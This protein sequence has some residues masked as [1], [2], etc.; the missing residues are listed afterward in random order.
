MKQYFKTTKVHHCFNQELNE[1]QPKKCKC[2]KFISREFA[3]GL[4]SDGVADWIIIYPQGVSSFDIILKGI[5][6]KTPRAQTI[7]KAHIQRYIDQIWNIGIEAFEDPEVLAHLEMYHDIEMVERLK[8]FRTIGLDLVAIKTM[9]DDQGNLKGDAGRVLHNKII[10]DADKLKLANAVDDPFLGE[11]W[12]MPIGA[13][14]QRTVVG[15][16]VPIGEEK[17]DKS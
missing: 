7:E 5:A 10:A 13:G 17:L 11:S 16:N 8:L 15:K 3:A 1:P 2:R 12:F 14:D 6:G 9:S 4:V